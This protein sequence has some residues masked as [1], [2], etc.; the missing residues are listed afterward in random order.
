MR[1]YRHLR[2]QFHVYNCPRRLFNWVQET[3]I[4]AV[5]SVLEL[6]FLLGAFFIRSASRDV[7]SNIPFPRESFSLIRDRRQ[8][9]LGFTPPG[10]CCF[11]LTVRVNK[12]LSNKGLFLFWRF[13]CLPPSPLTRGGV[14]L[15]PIFSTSHR[16][17]LHHLG[18][19]SHFLDCG[20][21]QWVYRLGL[22]EDIFEKFNEEFV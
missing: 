16:P 5:F 11:I 13:S 4:I 18:P 10:C 22:L 19:L 12:L 15:S 17:F 7:V 3:S 20:I 8:V 9:G 21:G 14:R 6:D 2:V 1:S